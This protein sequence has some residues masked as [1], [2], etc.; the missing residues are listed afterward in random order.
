MK[1]LIATDAW[2]P[3]IN[4]VVTTLENTVT[5]LK[6]MGHSVFVIES[7][8]FKSF[9]YPFYDEIPVAIPSMKKI[10]KMIQDFDPDYIHISTEATIGIA[11]RKYCLKNKLKFTTAYHTKFPEYFKEHFYLPAWVGY[12]FLKWY[13]KPSS[14]VMAAT[15][16]LIKHLKEKGFKNIETWD[17][18]VDT[19][20]FSPKPRNLEKY[21]DEHR[22]IAMY[23]GR[24]S[25]EKNIEAFLSSETQGKKYVIG[26]GPFLETYKNKY[27]DA[28]YLGALKCQ[29]LAEAYS[30]ADVMVFPSK[31]DTFGLVIVEALACG[32]PVAAY[33]V[34]GPI[35][36]LTDKSGSMDDD[37]ET[38]IGKA[39]LVDRAE[40]RKRALDFSWKHCTEQ[41]YSNLRLAHEN[42]NDTDA[43]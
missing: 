18:G 19:E 36:I 6:K 24:V 15:P 21:P 9:D 4:G 10:R 17:R 20:L 16:T 8:C 12:K 25:Y 37:L 5:E 23:V 3:Q 22:P 30:N 31:T 14:V 27:P 28:V 32:T 41:F 1:I 43:K 13:H 39:L 2:Y 33:P 29:A 38:A 7:G 40:S 26:S 34:T 42:T 11:V 35:D